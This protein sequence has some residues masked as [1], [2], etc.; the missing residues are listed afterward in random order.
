MPLDDKQQCAVC[1]LLG[2]RRWRHDPYEGR[3]WC[4]DT[5]TKDVC[6]HKRTKVIDVPVNANQLDTLTKDISCL[7]A[8]TFYK[9]HTGEIEA[10][11]L[12]QKLKK[13]TKPAL[14]V[15][16][17]RN[18]WV[19]AELTKS[20]FFI[21]DSAPSDAVMRDIR[22][23]ARTLELPPPTATTVPRQIRGSNQCGIFAAT[24]L[25]MRARQ[26][27]IPTCCTKVDLESLRA[28]A[29]PVT[30][31]KQAD[32]IF[33]R[34]VTGGATALSQATIRELLAPATEGTRVAHTFRFEGETTQRTWFAT[35]T[36]VRGA[37]TRTT[38]HEVEYD[39]NDELENGSETA[40][41]PP[42]LGDK[43]ETL[44]LTIL[45]SAAA[46]HSATNP[47]T[48]EPNREQDDNAPVMTYRRD[49][50]TTAMHDTSVSNVPTQW[51]ASPARY[52][53]T[54]VS[55][56]QFLGYEL[57]TF[58]EAEERNRSSLAWAAVTT[59]VRRKHVSDL[60]AFAEFVRKN[61]SS[62]HAPLQILLANYVQNI[63]TQRDIAWST[64]SRMIG[65]LIGAFAALPYYSNTG[66]SLP[67]S[68]WHAVKELLTVAA[69]E[70]AATG[71]REPRAATAAEVKQALDFLNRENRTAEA[72]ALALCWYTAQRPC[73]VLLLQTDN[74]SK[75][76]QSKWKARFQEGKVIGKIEAYHIHFRVPD[77]NAE[78]IIERHAEERRGHRFLFEFAS[79]YRRT[80][81][82]TTIASALRVS[83]GNLELRSLRRG[84]LQ[85]LHK[86]GVTETAL[87]TYSRHTTVDALRRY[88]GW[89]AEENDDHKTVMDAAEALT[90][91]EI[92][93]FN[94]TSWARFS[95]A[96]W[97]ISTEHPPPAPRRTIDR[98]RYPIAAK[99]VTKQPCNLEALSREAKLRTEATRENWEQDVQWLLDA[100][101]YEAIPFS[102]NTARMSCLSDEH[103]NQLLDVHHIVPVDKN[104]EHRISGSVHVFKV[105]EDHK[106]RFRCIQHPELANEAYRGLTGRQ[107]STRRS[108][109]EAIIRHEGFIAFDMASYYPQFPIT[110]RVSYAFAFKT[111][112]G[113]Y[114][115]TR[116]VTGARW[117][118][119]VATSA[120]KV[121]SETTIQGVTVDTCVD[122]VRFS[123]S[124]QQTTEAAWEFVQRCKRCDVKLNEVDVYTATKAQVAQ[125]YNDVD[126]E[127]FFGEVANYK[128]KSVKCR[129]R[130]ITRLRQYLE[131]ASTSR[132]THRV[133][134]GL[135][136]ML[137]YTSETLGEPLHR[138]RA[139]RIWFSR[140]ARDL[141]MD[142]TLWDAPTKFTPPLAKLTEWVDEVTANRPATVKRAPTPDTVVFIDACAKGYAA[143]M[144]KQDTVS[145]LIQHRWTDAEI[146]EQE[147][148]KSTV[149]EPE[150]IAQVSQHLEGSTTLFVS[151]H[152]QFVEALHTGSSLS[153]SNETRIQRIQPW[154]RAIYEPGVLNL[155]DKYSRFQSSQLSRED[156][157]EAVRRARWYRSS[158][159]CGPAYGIVGRG[160]SRPTRLH[161]QKGECDQIPT[162]TCFEG[163]DGH[164][165]PPSF[166]SF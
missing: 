117:S 63:R 122:N 114:R 129:P 110:E 156:A 13:V 29:D 11:T 64:V 152:E 135:Y 40:V 81:F 33:S 66:V 83:N 103:L 74:L 153:E 73:D 139:V 96:E 97:A 142:N 3:K 102:I 67:I 88:L 6:P 148:H 106:Q 23:D 12:R 116:L 57:L 155:A 30:F 127:G 16:H 9:L 98:T 62:R 37:T 48:S 150:A 15:I 107:N 82:I 10:S 78:A 104:E 137:L 120:T 41:L 36:K 39:D 166:S 77:D 17:V 134:F 164:P 70:G 130:H 55:G 46:N 121:L 105:P 2:P 14:F 44:E 19:A 4:N 92:S 154:T 60:A 136:A 79:A 133:L 132:P 45:P 95:G 157:L 108:A 119:N 94:P 38:K 149:S 86:R 89:N 76:G 158:R 124:A 58:S 20:N 35:V 131:D 90:G 22:R 53:D 93:D 118:T 159:I 50:P 18:H 1:A 34:L 69:R 7:P 162:D 56:A 85:T 75:S 61:E 49:Y 32:Q 42:D 146:G 52:A 160:R 26:Q 31:K 109:R 5:G 128:T 144:V 54:Q 111:K 141:A 68:R 123:G 84:S 113:W 71:T 147:V 59:G 138:W 72:C 115:M 80:R 51:V 24:F 143:I 91:G 161:H 43:V 112:R 126:K 101:R 140:R 25:H 163:K 28:Y 8:I 27:T 65:S 151:D 125:L 47:S 145:P 99:A 100:S 165:V 87:L 21:F